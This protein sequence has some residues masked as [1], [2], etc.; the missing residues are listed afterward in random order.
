M[1]MRWKRRTYMEEVSG[2]ASDGSHADETDGASLERVSEDV[3]GDDVFAG[4]EPGVDL[5]D[6]AEEVEREREGQLGDGVG[7]H[8]WEDHGGD[9][10]ALGCRG[11]DL[12]RGKRQVMKG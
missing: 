7:V 5:L 6:P 12:K 11:V 4:G 9:A 1:S 10:E 2:R 8:P 3:Y